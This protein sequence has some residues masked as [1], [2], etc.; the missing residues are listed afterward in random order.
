MSV[1]TGRRTWWVR[2]SHEPASTV[3]PGL[4]RISLAAGLPAYKLR[5]ITGY[6]DAGLYRGSVDPIH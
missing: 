1:Y 6:T 4:K 3:T 2:S 5:R